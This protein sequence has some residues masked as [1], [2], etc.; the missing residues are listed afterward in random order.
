[1][2]GHDGCTSYRSRQSLI[3]VVDERS[4]RV[5]QLSVEAVA[6]WQLLQNRDRLL[7]I[8]NISPAPPVLSN[9]LQL[10]P[11]IFCLLDI[12]IEVTPPGV[13]GLP[14]FL[15]PWGFHVRT[16]LVMLVLGFLKVWPSHPQLLLRISISI[17]AW[18]VLSQRSL[19]LTLSIQFFSG[20]GLQM[21]GSLSAWSCLFATFPLRTA[22]RTL[23]LC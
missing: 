6:Y 10:L 8:H 5:H 1:M 23:Q 11:A 21:S 19:L 3:C 2:K 4:R 18:C 20:N 16:C 22:T 9:P 12:C 14:L 15:L 17:W 7:T 13:F